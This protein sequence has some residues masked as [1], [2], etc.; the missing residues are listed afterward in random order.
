M[1]APLRQRLFGI[2]LE[3]VTVAKRGF[4]VSNEGVR[5]N[6]EKIGGIFVE[7]YHSALRDPNPQTLATHLNIVIE[8]EY[9]GFAFEGAG[10]GLALLDM[11]TPWPSNRVQRFMNGPGNNHYYMIHVG[12]GWA[13]AR[14]HRGISLLKRL[15]PIVCWLAIEGYGFHETYFYAAKTVNKRKRPKQLTGY[16]QHAFDQGIGRCLWFVCGS[17]V[18]RIAATIAAFAFERQPDLWSGVGL[19]STYAGGVD[20]DAL[21][22]LVIAA[23]PHRSQLAQGATFAAK[24]RW[25]AGNPT[26]HTDIACQVLCGCSLDEVVE[27]FDVTEPAPNQNSSEPVYELWRRNIQTQYEH[28]EV[29]S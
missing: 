12:V 28:K 20:T 7:G 19:S 27:I 23:G 22:A 29:V 15:D 3:E 8:N 13:M 16:A 10:M 1:L 24:A 14:L 5:E 21:N 6:L 4:L 9:R 26:A 2:S 17:D 25:R 18:E 11:L